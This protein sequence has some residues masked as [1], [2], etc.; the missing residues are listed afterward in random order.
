[1]INTQFSLSIYVSLYQSF[2]SLYL[3]PHLY[4]CH[5]SL[6]FSPCLSAQKD[7]LSTPVLYS[8]IICEKINL[9]QNLVDVWV[10]F[11]I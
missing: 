11:K 8:H 2:L 7:K 9:C 1:M 6:F 3:P 5:L 4:L 10:T